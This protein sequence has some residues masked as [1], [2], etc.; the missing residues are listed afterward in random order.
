M[1]VVNRLKQLDSMS[2]I[3]VGNYSLVLEGE[4]ISGYVYGSTS[5]LEIRTDKKA[6]KEELEDGWI[7]YISYL[8]E[9]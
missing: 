2:G 8:T 5:S 1:N 4:E 7:E 3:Y 9:R 6:I